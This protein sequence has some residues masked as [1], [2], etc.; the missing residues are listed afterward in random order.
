M[1]NEDIPV[2]EWVD[3]PKG[4]TIA[5]DTY[6]DAHGV[7]RSSVNHAIAVWHNRTRGNPPCG[8]RVTKSSEIVYDPDTG[9][10][11]CPV[12]FEVNK[13]KAALRMLFG[14]IEDQVQPFDPTDRD[15]RDF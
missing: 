10:P 15:F 5:P 8:Y 14:P 4:M 13:K 12:C 9:A 1:E 3:V 7:L 2:G 6:V 11:W